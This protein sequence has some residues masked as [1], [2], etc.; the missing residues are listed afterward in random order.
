MPILIHMWISLHKSYRTFQNHN[1]NDRSSISSNF[2]RL[3]KNFDSLKHLLSWITAAWLS[4][5]NKMLSGTH[6][7]A[8]KSAL[9]GG[10]NPVILKLFQLIR[11]EFSRKS[12]PPRLQRLGL[13]HKNSKRMVKTKRARISC[14]RWKRRSTGAEHFPV[15]STPPLLQPQKTIR[16][17]MANVALSLGEMKLIHTCTYFFL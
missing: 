15:S 2:H 14:L 11:N 5:T 13:Q 8:A 12:N 4:T 1:K 17:L 7:K 10:W 16:L 6:R 3:V 9:G